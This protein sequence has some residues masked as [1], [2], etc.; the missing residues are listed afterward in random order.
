M[1]IAAA[2]MNVNDYTRGQRY[3]ILIS[4]MLG[5]I[6][7]FY[8]VLIFPFLLPAIQKSMSISLTQA[9]TLQALTLFGSAIGGALFG[10]I[11]DRFGRKTSLQF[12]IA[13]F[14]VAA[15]LSAFAW[16][17]WSLALLR[18]AT[19]IGLGGEYGAG[20]VLF[21][22]AWPKRNRGLGTSV[23]Q[24]CAVIASSTASVVG[25]WLISTFSTEWSWRIGLLTGGVPI[26]LIIFIRYFMPE[27]K[28]WQQ[29]NELRKSGD[30]KSRE[31]VQT[32]P[33]VDIFRNGLARQTITALIWMM[34]YMLCYYSILS[35]IP[36]L[37]LRD[38]H[39]PGDVVRTTAV[40]LSV[41]SGIAYISNGFFNDRAGRRLGAIVPALFWIGSLVG[42]AIWGHELYA[43]SKLEWPMF[44]LYIVFGIGNVSLAVNGVWI[45][46]LYPVGLRATA[47]STFYMAGRGL[48]SIASIAVPI[49]AE[50]LAG[51][52]LSGMI[53]VA[54]PCAFVFVLASLMLPETLGRDL[55]L[56]KFGKESQEDFGSPI[57]ETAKQPG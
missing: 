43:G 34:S 41:F 42:M 49:A 36:S 56:E 17:F 39:T 25:I 26:L 33:L 48:G 27:S 46:E 54:L 6:L 24:G 3:S 37:L 21:N 9:G 28:I 51:G 45:S 7:D 1:A 23:L 11:G 4:A 20:M 12:T 5:Y 30:A 8:D 55:S 16:N 40:L 53:V 47:V 19:G 2:D 10:T 50:H 35:F 15:I 57:L 22:E 32:T 29:Y 18:L 13:L 31:Q 44:W 38:M 52:L 14:S